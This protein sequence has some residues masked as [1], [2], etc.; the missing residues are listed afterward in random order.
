M[1]LGRSKV[2]DTPG[3]EWRNSIAGIVHEFG[4]V[5]GDLSEEYARRQMVILLTALSENNVRDEILRMRDRARSFVMLLV[6]SFIACSALSFIAAVWSEGDN[7]GRYAG[8]GV[9]FGV[10]AIIL[11]VY[12]SEGM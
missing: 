11:A 4:A 3:L 7:G 8:T 5:R 9:V 12:R 10:L 2:Q 6:W 1:R